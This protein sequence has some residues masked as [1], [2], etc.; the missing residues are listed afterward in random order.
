MDLV[1]NDAVLLA[2][3]IASLIF[4]AVATGLAWMNWVRAGGDL[5][6]MLLIARL[7]VRRCVVRPLKTRKPDSPLL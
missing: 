2:G 6:E 5:R 3:A 1:T 7:F 4:L